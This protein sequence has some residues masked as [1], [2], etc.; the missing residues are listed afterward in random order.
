MC[1]TVENRELILTGQHAGESWDAAQV[2][3]VA[4]NHHLRLSA[5]KKLK[6]RTS[7][8]FLILVSRME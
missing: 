8:T 2:A 1:G 5:A 7:A 3:T 4:E 6:N